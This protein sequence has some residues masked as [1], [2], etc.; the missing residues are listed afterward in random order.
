MRLY[1]RLR[2]AFGRDRVFRYPVA[3]GTNLGLKSAPVPRPPG[4][5]LLVVIGPTW[6][7][8]RSP[9]GQASLGDPQD[10]VR[11]EVEAALH[12][13]LPLVLV[14]VAGARLPGTG[15]LPVGLRD[16]IHQ[17]AIRL[18]PEQFDDDVR[19]LIDRL[20]QAGEP[21]DGAAQESRP[22]ADPAATTLMVPE[23]PAS[24]PAV[25]GGDP[26]VADD[27]EPRGTAGEFPSRDETAPALSP[28]WRPQPI[29]IPPAE[30]APPARREA[31]QER[32]SGDGETRKPPRP[33]RPVQSLLTTKLARTTLT[34]LFSVASI[35]IAAVAIVIHSGNHPGPHS[36]HHVNHQGGQATGSCAPSRPPGNLSPGGVV[37]ALYRDIN[38]R[39]FCAA[40][41]LG[42]SS[43]TPGETYKAYVAGFSDLRRDD[44]TITS[45]SPGNPATVN[46]SLEVFNRNSAPV[47]YTGYYL[48]ENGRITAGHLG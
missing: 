7:A 4:F 30:P 39:N 45:V 15:E 19:A 43:I 42:A 34:A 33:R 40:W 3:A 41:N 35:A 25:S 29:P 24:P 1:D 5:T 26:A 17:P 18:T 16:L 38:H 44:I 46:V 27:Q 8:S 23:Y 11:A 47:T 13:D 22:A 28:T 14:L 48:V 12:H 32:P 36:R 37:R 2:Q 20:G 10:P 31:S 6:I 9:S 21:A